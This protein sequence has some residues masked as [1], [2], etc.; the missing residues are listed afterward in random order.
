MRIFLET[1]RLALRDFTDSDV[2]DLFDLHNDPDVM[3]HVDG[4]K[5]TPR[6]V[7]VEETLPRYRAQYERSPDF[8]CWT[9]VEKA[10]GEFVGW[11][12]LVPA[13]DAA[14][15]D[16]ELDFR[17]RASSWARGYATEGVRALIIKGFRELGV[18]RVSACTMTVNA[19]GRRV[20]EKAG[21]SLV[22]TFHPPAP[23]AGAE[24]L[25]GAEQGH[26]AYAV[27]RDDR[28]PRPGDGPPRIL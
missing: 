28:V 10:T 3:R 19:A 5:R 12:A 9:A 16:V 7:I 26:V 13:D 25:P 22:R 15:E 24:A 20:L 1:G 4:G 21:L 14:P 2:D 8:G 17:I 6:S 23:D 27:C 11:F 18:R